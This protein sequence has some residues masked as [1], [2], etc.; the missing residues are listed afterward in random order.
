MDVSYEDEYDDSPPGLVEEI[1][2]YK[3]KL[4]D[5]HADGE[6]RDEQ[7]Y[8]MLTNVHSRHFF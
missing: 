7:F 5:L 2:K 3:L 8:E 4:P 1:S 6:N